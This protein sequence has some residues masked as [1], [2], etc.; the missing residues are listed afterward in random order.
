[1]SGLDGPAFAF[2]DAVLTTLIRRYTRE[3]GVR[4]L[5]RQ[6]AKIARKRARQVVDARRPP[7]PI[8]RESLVGYLGV[9][10]RQ[11]RMVPESSNPGVV[12]GLAWTPVG[13]EILRVECT[14]L[15]GKGRLH[16]TGSLGDVMKESAQIA[17]TLVRER[18]RRYGVDPEL[19]H[20]T[21]IHLHVPEGS[22]PKDGP[23]AGIA[24]TLALVSAMTRQKVNPKLAFTGEVSLVGKI[25]AI[26][27]LPEKALAAL[28]AGVEH[29][30]VPEENEAEIRELP[31]EAKRGLKISRVSHIDEVLKILFKASAKAKPEEK[32]SRSKGLRRLSRGG[33]NQ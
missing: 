33:P 12:T 20:K 21:D 19:F 26:G 16:L 27:G 1:M 3:A 7:G 10:I 30:L 25:H 28:Q 4:Q 8:T 17:L 22:I 9:P 18:A 14:L 11:E 29:I 32:G 6:L 31:G 5:A 13:G 23:S 15:S 2:D 24:M